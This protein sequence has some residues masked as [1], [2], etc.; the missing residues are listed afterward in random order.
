[1]EIFCFLR[2]LFVGIARDF[3]FFPILAERLVQP[4]PQR[5]QRFL[6]L[7]PN[8]VDLRIVGDLAQLDMG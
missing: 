8:D 6:K 3:P 4:F 7:L 1:M 2:P 5:F